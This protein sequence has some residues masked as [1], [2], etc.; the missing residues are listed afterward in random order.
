VTRLLITNVGRLFTATEAGVVVDAAVVVDDDRIAWVGPA[1]DAPGGWDER[2]DVE[3]A[4]VT[5]GLIDAHTH[6]VYAGDRLDEIAR[7]SSGAGYQEIAAAGGGIRATVAA[8]RAASEAE[9]TRLVR[10]RLAR[11]LDGGTTTV[12]AKT[13][14]HLDRSGELTA[15][16]L[17]ATLAG[18]SMSTGDLPAASGSRGDRAVAGAGGAGHGGLA[19]G[20][21]GR[22]GGEVGAVGG[23]D[24]S[25]VLPRVEVTFLGAHDV[26]RPGV[27]HEAWVDEVVGWSGEAAAAGAR[28]VDVF[29]DAGYFSVDQARRVLEAGR[30]AGLLP[31]IH[32]DEL[33]RTG[34][35][36]LAAEVGAVSADHL[37]CVVDDDARAL[38]AAGVVATLC[39]VTALALRR[40]P[41][42]RLLVDRG[43]RLALG[44]DH[45]PGQSGTTSMSLVVGLAVH[46]LGLSVDEAL[47]AATAGGARSLALDDRGTIRPGALADL[48]AWDADHEA[49]FAWDLGLRPCRVWKGGRSS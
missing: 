23:T 19:G 24:G 36:L 37:L 34:G 29:C 7:R 14:Y 20:V 12:E 35:S 2:I 1:A 48:V 21:G 47:T 45:N 33:E 22:P 40:T 39:P 31:R 27:A 4:L 32:A 26:G 6:P 42:A 38:S 18:R 9:L 17:L 15:V 28:F 16:H 41:P 3:G 25:A 46:V 10:A 13:G 5:P 49:A 44:S 30:A 43:V 11:W 8:T